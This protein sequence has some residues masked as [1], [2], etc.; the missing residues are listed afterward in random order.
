MV[1]MVALL[2]TTCSPLA[3]YVKRMKEPG[4]TFG[5][6]DHPNAGYAPINVDLY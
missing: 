6:E 2:Y 4:A 3:K 1:T 5:L